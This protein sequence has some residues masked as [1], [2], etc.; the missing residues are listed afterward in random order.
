LKFEKRSLIAIAGCSIRL[1]AG[2]GASIR[3]YFDLRSRESNC[4]GESV[5]EHHL[6]RMIENKLLEMVVGMIESRGKILR[7]FKNLFEKP[8]LL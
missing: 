8:K 3:A 6:G 4:D 5:D 7:G 1:D 2:T